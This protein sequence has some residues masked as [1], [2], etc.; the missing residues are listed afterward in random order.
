MSNPEQLLSI[1][2]NFFADEN[3]QYVLNMLHACIDSA[4]NTFTTQSMVLG[5]ATEGLMKRLCNE[6]RLK[7]STKLKSWGEKSLLDID[8]KDEVA[9]RELRN[10]SAH[11]DFVLSDRGDLQKRVSQ[12]GRLQNLL[13]KIMLQLMQYEGDFFNHHSGNQEP[14]PKADLEELKG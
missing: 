2:T 9:W 1:A 12:M 3:N 5:A 10:L 13:V 7:V 11:G 14:F 8:A 6:P 4:D